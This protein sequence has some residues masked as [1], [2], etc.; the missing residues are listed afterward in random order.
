MLFNKE[1]LIRG[2]IAAKEDG[3]KPAVIKHIKTLKDVHE[4]R[5]KKMER[6]R[7]PRRLTFI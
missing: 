6:V 3:T 5:L 4:L 2:L 1:A 7:Q